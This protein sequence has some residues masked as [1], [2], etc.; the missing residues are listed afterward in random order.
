MDKNSFTGFNVLSGVGL[1]KPPKKQSS[2]EATPKKRSTPNRKPFSPKTLS[3]A[4]TRKP[5]KRAF[6]SPVHP[7]PDS[8]KRQTP[9]NRKSFTPTLTPVKKPYVPPYPSYIYSEHTWGGKTPSPV[10]TP[11]ELK[12]KP[13]DV[14][15]ELPLE[16]E[17]TARMIGQLDVRQESP[18]Q[19]EKLEETSHIMGP[20]QLG[21]SPLQLK[22][23][24]CIE[25]RQPLQL[26]ETA[27]TMQPK[28]LIDDNMDLS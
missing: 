15:E 26:E 27:C 2:L 18:L 6:E 20:P 21:G 10:H 3:P 12:W 22:G 14:R 28:R 24:A 4:M 11:P 9:S 1:G 8:N 13:K 25:Q 17:G 23:T 5:L 16:L 7:T 19:L